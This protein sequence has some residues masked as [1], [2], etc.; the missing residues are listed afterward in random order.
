MRLE[1][2]VALITGAAAAVQGE[3]MGLGGASAWLFVREG[4]K[5]VLCDINDELGQ[6]GV[7][8]IRES[9]GEAMFVHLDVT[10]EQ[11]WIDAIQT[12]VSTYGRLDIVVNNAGTGGTFALEET[13]EEIWDEQM[14]VHAKGAFFGTK[15][16]LPKMRKV[17][18]G[19]IINTSSI[20]G[21]VGAP[22]SSAYSAAKGAIRAFTKS[23]AVQY[24]KEGIR[25]NSVHPGF[26]MTPMTEKRF[27]VPEIVNERLA[28]VPMGRLGTAEEIAYGILFLA[29]DEA[30]FVTG[31][32]LVI[33][34]G[35]LA[36]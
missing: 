31:A 35:F 34:G 4:A 17:G 14:N 15:H 18:G 1:G 32:E 8:Q 30:S 20:M 36:Q 2:K 19:S 24:A 10:K 7:S 27:T 11:E 3:L 9:G 12:T 33:D 26:T 22:R 13:T 28:T 29:S 21:M 5:V 6:K 23:A 25:V 16:A